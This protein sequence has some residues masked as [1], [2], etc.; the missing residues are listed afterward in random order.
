MRMRSLF[1]L[2]VVGIGC[3]AAAYA[4]TAAPIV[5]PVTYAQGPVIKANTHAVA[6]DVVVTRGQDEPVTSL[7]KDDFQILEDGK[8]QPID[9]FE[10]HTVPVAPAAIAPLPALPLHVY[11]N[12]PA[13]PQSDS[14]NVVLLDSL[15]TPRQDQS[16][17]RQ[18]ILEFLKTMKP[19]ARIAIFMLGSRLRLIQGFSD[20]PAVL[21]AAVEDK[22]AGVDPITTEVSRGRTEDDEDKREVE[23]RQKN[24]V[25][26]VASLQASQV[27]FAEMESDNRV[28][29]TLEALRNLGRNLAGIPGRKNLIWFA[30][31]YPVD[32][33]PKSLE[34][35]PFN[36]HREH[37]EAIK[38]T[39]D[40]LMLSKVAL[41]PIDAE[42]MMNDHPMDSE[43]DLA[44][45]GL[46]AGLLRN[47]MNG[48]NE[49]AAKMSAME[50][51]AAET[52]GEAIF[53]NNDL[54]SALGRAIHNGAHYYTIVYTPT[55]KDMNGQFRRVQVKLSQGKYNLSYRRGYYADDSSGAVQAKFDGKPGDKSGTQAKQDVDM[56]FGYLRS[57]MVRGM[58]SATQILYGVRVVPAAPQPAVDAKRAGLNAKLSGPTIRYAVD[59]L[60][61]SKQVHFEATPEGNHVGRIRVEL[62]AYDRD[63]KA[64]NWTGA[65][66][67]S[68]MDAATYAD[69]QKSGVP[70]HM[71]IDVPNTQVYLSTGIYDL[72]ANTAGTLEVPLDSGSKPAT[73]AMRTG[74]ANKPE[75]K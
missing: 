34:K 16:Q 17:V 71:E 13:G 58:P 75:N 37:T 9:F 73:V 29:M 32:F 25:A 6:V 68:A 55:N 49:R 36:D 18:Q 7:S 56:K 74:P 52:G 19:E 30:S 51:L 47:T 1:S 38:E 21:R 28:A 5:V 2:A 54:N 41:Y 69:V 53:N 26:S 57:L 39:A 27:E 4:Q 65:T 33:F 66:M 20:D 24:R 63:G 8:S 11:T 42:G 67:H 62:L 48:A 70:V 35:Q 45:A 3:A 60:V 44:A 72:D 59:F 15:N 50:Q 43:H 61:D 46:G 23:V 10:E 31:Q 22:K 40:L 12:V 14:V 64:L